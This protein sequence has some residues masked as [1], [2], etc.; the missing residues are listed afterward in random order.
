AAG[1]CTPQDMGGSRRGCTKSVCKILLHVLVQKCKKMQKK[2]KKMQ[3]HLHISKKSSTFVAD[4][5]MVPDQTINTLKVMKKSRRRVTLG[6][7]EKVRTYQVGNKQVI[8]WRYVDGPLMGWYSVTRGLY[9]EFAKLFQ[10]EE[11]AIK[12][13]EDIVSFHNRQLELEGL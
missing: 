12:R 7:R 8:I 1:A 2:C 10:T 9:P 13:A 6:T 3:K 11:S 5:G 4:L